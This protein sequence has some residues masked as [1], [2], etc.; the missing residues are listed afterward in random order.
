MLGTLKNLGKPNERKMIVIDAGIATEDNIALLKAQQVSYIAVSRKQ[1]YDPLLWAHSQEVKLPLNDKQT[2]LSVR[3][4]IVESHSEDTEV[5]REA[6]LLCH[7]PQKAIKEQQIAERR[8]QRFETELE[9]IHV[10]LTKPGT[11]KKYGKIMERIGRLKQKYGVGNC[12]DIEI[13]QYDCVVKAIRFKKKP[14]DQSNAERFG[15][16]VIRTDRIDSG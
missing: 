16:Y 7:S 12:Y 5:S 13:E 10:G 15:E 14:T 3:L 4:A 11:Q 2:E 1:H 6:F 9:R 8:M